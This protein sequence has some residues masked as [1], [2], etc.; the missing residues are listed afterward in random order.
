MNPPDKP[1]MQRVQ[2]MRGVG[3]VTP[4]HLQPWACGWVAALDRAPPWL[5]ELAMLRHRH[6]IDRWLREFLDSD[7][8]APRDGDHLCDYAVACLLL[9]HERR[10]ISW[11]T[12]LESVGDLVDGRS[13]GRKPCEYFYDM[14]T[15][16]EDHE[17]DLVVEQRQVAV[18][19]ADFADVMRE[20]KADFAPFAAAFRRERGKR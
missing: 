18:V 1:T 11:A 2:E 17:Y 16:L 12:C 19:H 15:E 3:L 13:F 8:R 10:A 4:S 20:V 14:L 7:P 5:C 6:E 9:R